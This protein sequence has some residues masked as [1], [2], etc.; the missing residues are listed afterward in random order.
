MFQNPEIRGK[1]TKTGL[2]IFKTVFDILFVGVEYKGL[3]GREVDHFES[4]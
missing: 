3:G 1:K 4:F 2:Y